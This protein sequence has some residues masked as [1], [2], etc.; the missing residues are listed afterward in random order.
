MSDAFGP[1]CHLNL[2]G[3]MGQA[4]P[5]LLW[6]SGDLLSANYVQSVL[7]SVGNSR[8]RGM[9]TCYATSGFE[10]SIW[11]TTGPQGPIR[12][13]S[14]DYKCCNVL[15][16]NTRPQYCSR[17]HWRIH[18]IL[19]TSHSCGPKFLTASDRALPDEKQGTWTR[20]D[21]HFRL[22]AV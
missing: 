6:A 4:L 21:W 17:H 14:Y 15:R 8:G 5:S 12:P 1:A 18:H 2:E 16:I 10:L 22:S 13:T 9:T 3:K 7:S 20:L 19:P 11:H